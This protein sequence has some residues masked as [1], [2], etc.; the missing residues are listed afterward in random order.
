MAVPLV[1]PL[2]GLLLVEPDALLPHVVPT[3]A[4]IAEQP[5]NL[6]AI[7]SFL[8]VVALS[9]VLLA[10]DTECRRGELAVVATILAR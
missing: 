4:S 1:L 9:E 5:E 6:S 10:T 2:R 3:L 7:P 8:R